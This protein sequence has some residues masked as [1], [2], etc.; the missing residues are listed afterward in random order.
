M[1]KLFV[2]T[3]AVALTLALVAGNAWAATA[4]MLTDQQLERVWGGQ[5]EVEVEE[6]AVGVDGSAASQADRG[7]VSGAG[8][9]SVSNTESETETTTVT[10]TVT[11]TEN[12]TE[13][14]TEVKAKNGG[15]ANNGSGFV[16]RTETNNDADDGS[17]AN[18]GR[19][20]QS[21]SGSQN[22]AAG[23]N[24]SNAMLSAIAQQNNIASI[25]GGGGTVEGLGVLGIFA[26]KQSNRAH[27]NM[28]RD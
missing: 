22:E 24:L 17:I 15:I 1:K 4:M 23:Q 13:N 9:G 5:L 21:V 12:E 6:V 7:G 18:S 2:A 3:L 8:S 16:K 25:G 26:I 19:I 27:I 14:E 28:M 10:K 11:K 20:S